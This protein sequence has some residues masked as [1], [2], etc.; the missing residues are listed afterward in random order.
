M[1]QWMNPGEVSNYP[2][3]LASIDVGMNSIGAGQNLYLVFSKL[4]TIYA[5][6]AQTSVVRGDVNGD[7]RVDVEDVNGV[8][9]IILGLAASDELRATS[10]ITGDGRVDVEDVNA[11]INI[12][13][14]L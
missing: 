10:D 13:L 7:G 2:V 14:K 1:A 4:E 6:V 8:I 12:I 9:N 11:I 3:T 5:G